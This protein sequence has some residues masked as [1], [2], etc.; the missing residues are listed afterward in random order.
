MGGKRKREVDENGLEYIY[1]PLSIPRN[2]IRLLSLQ[3]G[4]FDD[5]LRCTLRNV[6]LDDDP[7]YHALS[8]TWGDPTNKKP[9]LIDGSTFNVTVNLYDALQHFQ[10]A[11]GLRTFWIDA[12]CI[13]QNDLLERSKQVLRMRDIYYKADRVEVWIGKGDE[14][15]YAAMELVQQLGKS[16]PDPEELLSG[17]WT[18][19]YHDLFIPHFQDCTPEILKALNCLY[20]RPWWTRVWVVQEVSLANQSQA[21]VTCGRKTLRWVDFLIAA[22]AIEECWVEVNTILWEKFP[23]EPLDSFSNGIRLAQCRRVRDDQ[24]PFTLL[25]L[26]HQH[27]DCVATDARDCVYGLLGMSGDGH[28]MGIEP[29]YNLSPQMIYSDLVIKCVNSTGSLDILCACR[30]PRNLDDL[31]SWVPDW[32]TDQIVPGICQNQ[33]Y[34]GGDDFPGSTLSEAE[35]Y[36]SAGTSRAQVAFSEDGLHLTASGFV[37]GKIVGLGVI[38]DGMKFEDIETFG[39]ADENGKSGSDS[40]IFNNWFNLILDSPSWNEIEHTYGSPQNVLDAFCRVLVAGR[41]ARMKRL[42]NDTND[43]SEKRYVEG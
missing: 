37:F 19:S 40:E 20:R 29:D 18:I 27:R 41:D 15:D 32:S 26:L 4:S 21:R 7:E 11:S 16:V 34:C 25:E 5:E 30:S 12:L 13:N 35:K 1:E 10:N 31:P 28:Q 36:A 3:P 33:R 8:Y 14:S 23:D 9:V 42:L 38:D 2:E 43:T 17:P 24:P 22:Y 39:R 6:S